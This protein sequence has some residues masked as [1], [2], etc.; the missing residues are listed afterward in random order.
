M[1]LAKQTLEGVAVALAEYLLRAIRLVGAPFDESSAA[2]ECKPCMRRGADLPQRCK[3]SH[4]TRL[5]HVNVYGLTP[6]DRLGRRRA[7]RC[8][9]KYIRFLEPQLVPTEHEL[10]GPVAKE[11]S[12][13][14]REVLL[15]L[16][17]R[18]PLRHMTEI[19]KLE[20]CVVPLRLRR[21]LSDRQFFDAIL[22]DLVDVESDD[23]L[24]ALP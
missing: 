18:A 15:N 8:C 10:Q 9:I 24:N 19:G 1:K 11:G 22:N 21:N 4:R 16:A 12:V 17:N 7:I 6:D 3:T 13:D 14:A 23:P 5:P 20:D 2:K